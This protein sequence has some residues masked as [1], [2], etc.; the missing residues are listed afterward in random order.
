MLKYVYQMKIN[1]ETNLMHPKKDVNK[2][3]K[4]AFKTVVMLPL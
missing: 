4:D 2:S 1:S 3:M